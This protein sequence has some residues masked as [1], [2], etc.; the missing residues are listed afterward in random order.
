MLFFLSS[1][2][3]RRRVEFDTVLDYEDIWQDPRPNPDPQSSLQ[4][5]AGTAGKTKERKEGQ[6]E[7]NRRKAN[8]I[9]QENEVCQFDV[10][11]S[12]VRLVGERG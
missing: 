12:T 10:L 9:S 8:N 6:G 5:Q 3:R 11:G 4:R 2:R 1:N 7:G